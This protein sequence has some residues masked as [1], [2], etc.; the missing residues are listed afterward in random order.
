MKNHQKQAKNIG[1]VIH[2]HFVRAD[3][4][5]KLGLGAGLVLYGQKISKK[6]GGYGYYPRPLS[7]NPILS[8]ATDFAS[9]YHHEN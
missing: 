3:K 4:M 5:V 8:N 2:N 7:D 1:G 6:K 9:S